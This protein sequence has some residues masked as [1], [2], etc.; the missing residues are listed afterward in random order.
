MQGRNLDSTVMPAEKAALP[1]AAHVPEDAV[2]A[3]AVNEP[4]KKPVEE[5]IEWL[6]IE[7]AVEKNKLAPRKILV[8]VY[9]DWCGWCK[10][11]D[12]DVYSKPE[13]IDYLSRNWVVVRIN[14]EASTLAHYQG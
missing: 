5:T 11:M 8:D 10:R 13:M 4:T 6:S 12:R 3:P 2:Q 9:T 14:A 1:L 7:E